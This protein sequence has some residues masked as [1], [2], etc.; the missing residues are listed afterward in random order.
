[1]ND[2]MK[3]PQGPIPAADRRRALLG[4]L[5]LL[6]MVAGA[7][8]SGL[9]LFGVR[10]NT[11]PA[12]PEGMRAALP[13]TGG[14]PASAAAGAAG[15]AAARTALPALKPHSMRPGRTFRDCATC[16]EMVVVPP[17]RFDMG[18]PPDT[19]RV[20]LAHAFALGKYEVTQAEWQAVMGSDPAHF[21]GA[22]LPVEQVS[23]SDAQAFIDKLS[24]KTGKH[25]RLPSE[26]EWEYACRAG[27]ADE[28][29]GGNEADHVAWYGALG[30]AGGN[31]G[32]ATHPVGM[33]QPNA[34]GLYDMSGNVWEWVADTWH[35][36]YAG[37]PADGSAWQGGGAKRVIRGGSWQDY[38]L[39]AAAS[40][41]IYAGAAKRSSDL[42][43]RVARDLP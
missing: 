32:R 1:M 17:G 4:A 5:L 6:V 7:W 20:T 21:H 39:L 40:Y 19:H 26:A 23:W 36:G 28:Y 11:R 12:A 30:E 25:Y 10:V 24:R 22:R 2:D 31:S 41:R 8:L 13:E 14:A 29:C 42:G 27:G 37:A 3:P 18:E 16:P 35:P 9:L 33:K 38:P 15:P 43:L 34:L